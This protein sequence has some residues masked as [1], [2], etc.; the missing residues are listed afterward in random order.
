MTRRLVLCFALLLCARPVTAAPLTLADLDFSDAWILPVPSTGYLDIVQEHGA[1]GTTITFNQPFTGVWTFKYQAFDAWPVWWENGGL[2]LMPGIPAHA[3]Q[4]MTLDLQSVSLLDFALPFGSAA[5]DR[6]LFYDMVFT[7]TLLPTQ[8]I[9]VPEPETL[10]L[11]GSGVA[12]LLA[13]RRRRAAAPI[14]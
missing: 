2:Y 9:A 6:I 8:E 10:L 4:S 13:R 3:L 11:V 14:R 7:P 1:L 5:P 12:G